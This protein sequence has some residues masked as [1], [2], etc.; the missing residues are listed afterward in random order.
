MV[1]STIPISL[2]KGSKSGGTVGASYKVLALLELLQ[3]REKYYSVEEIVIRLEHLMLLGFSF[4]S[5]A[6]ERNLRACCKTL[7]AEKT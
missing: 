6:D 7:Q 4:K 5:L 2:G 3:Y 1:T